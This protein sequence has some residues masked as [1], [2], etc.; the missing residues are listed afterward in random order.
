[1]RAAFL[2]GPER[3]EVRDVAEGTVPTGLVA[4]DVVACGICGSDL[5]GWRHPERTMAAAGAALPGIGG[6]EV[7][8]RVVGDPASSRRVV[9]EPNLAGSCGVCAACVEGRAWFCRDRQSLPLWG[10]AE[11]MYVKPAGLFDVPENVDER[12][13]SLT[14]PLACAVHAI[15]A[16]HSAG[17]A[18]GSLEGR[19]VAVI[20]AGV[21][22]LL[23]VVAAVRL[24]A[25]A[26]A[27]VAR[28]PH[29]AACAAQLGASEGIDAA[30]PGL[31]KSLRAFGPDVVVEA[32]GGAADTFD[33]ALRSVRSGGEVVVLGIFDEP[34]QLDVRRAVFRELRLVFPV[35]YGAVAGR[36]DF[37]VALEYLA[38]DPGAFASLVSHRF[39]LGEA[40]EAFATAA[41]KNTGA[42]RVVVEP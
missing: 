4:V 12:V 21:A 8:G 34:Q 5:A 40:A 7:V 15:G 29:Q 13:A 25:E 22:G 20:G 1:M 28:Y 23:A 31:V 41:D 33:L 37:E 10:F 14:E 11:R 6:H 9:L 24:G 27:S 16:S 42:L 19:R 38:S 32:V 3:I 17:A 18:P 36:H 30:D 39:A 35:T 26:V 2:D